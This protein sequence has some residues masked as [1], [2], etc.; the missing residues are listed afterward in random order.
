MVKYRFQSIFTDSLIIIKFFILLTFYLLIS[1]NSQ[2]QTAK[3]YSVDKELSSSMVHDVLQDH[4]GQI[5]IATA[6][7]LNKYD[8]AKFTLY[9]KNNNVSGSILSNFVHVMCEDSQGNLFVGFAGGIQQYDFAADKFITIPLISESGDTLSAFVTSIIER[10]NGK[11]IIGTSGFGLFK[12]IRARE[13]GSFLAIQE[14]SLI[15]SLFIENLYEDSFQNLWIDTQ[16]KGV[17]CLADNNEW[18]N[19]FFDETGSQMEIRSFAED[20]N[21]NFYAGCNRNGMFIYD[22]DQKKFNLL[23]AKGYNNKLPINTLYLNQE[24]EILVGTE[25]EGLM[26]F[27]PINRE[28]S[29][30]NF[31]ISTFDFS[32]SKITSI[33]EDRVGNIWLGIYQKGVVMLPASSNNFQYIGYKSIKNNI[34]GSSNI[35]TLSKD[36]NSSLWVG[37]DGDGIYKL[38]TLSNLKTHYKNT[39]N[40]SAMPSTIMAAFEDSENNFWLGS[41]D[42][43]LVRLNR[44]TGH[45]DLM[46]H[47]LEETPDW[48]K[49]VF[50]IVEDGN[51]NLWIGTL[52]SGLYCYNLKTEQTKHF[53][54]E[55][56]ESFHSKSDEII[57]RFINSLLISSDDRLYIGTV[58]GLG[59]LDLKANSFTSAFGVNRLLPDYAINTIF[60]DQTGLIW[61]GTSQGLFNLDPISEQINSFSIQDG[62]P[63]NV[64]SSIAEDTVGNIWIS[65]N[66]GISKM[67]PKTA[68]FI[69][70]FSYDGLQGNEFTL[71]SGFSDKGRRFYFGGIHGIT[72]FNPLEIKDEGRKLD[73]FF[74][75]FYIH[76]RAVNVGMKSGPF[77]IID[78]PLI[79]ADQINL[80][81]RDNSFTIEFSSMD[82]SNPERISYMY[83]VGN[84]K[85]WISLRQGTNTV[86]FNDLSPGQYSFTVRAKD[87]NTISNEKEINIFIHQPWYFTNTAKI[88][89][90]LL[91]VLIIVLVSR[92][93]RQR[94]R[95]RQKIHE[96]IQAKKIND[97][98]LQFFINVAHEI[99]TPLSLIISPLKKLIQKDRDHERHKSYTIMNRNSVR[100]LHLVNQLMDIQKIDKGQLALKFEQTEI[101]G[102]VKELCDIFEEQL[103]LKNVNINFQFKTEEITAWID[104]GNFDKVIINVLSNAI[105]FTPVDGKIDIS[106]S[107]VEINLPDIGLNSFAQIV[108]SD[109]GIG[110]P[111]NELEKVFDCFYQVND[112]KHNSFDGTGIGLHLSRSIVELH[113]GT[114]T[115][116][117]NIDKEGCRF[118]I[119]IPLGNRHLNENEMLIDHDKHHAHETELTYPDLIEIED[120][121]KVK[122]GSKRKILVVDDDKEIAE[123]I[124]QELSIEY[125]VVQFLNGKEALSFVLKTPPDLVISDVVM[126]EM[127]G[128][129]LCRKIKQNVNINHVPVILLTAKSKEEDNLKGLGIGAEAYIVKPF[130]INILRKTVQNILKNRQM[131]R[132][133]FSGSQRQDDKIKKIALKS[134]DEKL[135]L[136]IIDVVNANISNPELNVEMLAHE[137]GISRVHLHRKLKELTNQST[138]D[139]VRNI[140]LHQ[141]ANLL[142]DKHMN[143]SEVAFAVGFT[144]IAHFSN[145]FKEFYGQPPS[146]YMETHQNQF[147]E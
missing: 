12:L 51:K 45:C 108:I 123:Y 126:P 136:R 131:L 46:N 54:G 41:Y 96:H 2:S 128:I 72:H 47:I 66:Y 55:K 116:K 103:K 14:P 21:G 92:E 83:K 38:D 133:S 3:F 89:Y 111:Q 37:T 40:A 58:I 44:K 109:S 113:H 104:P 35:T 60:E 91:F 23:P 24:G 17:Y 67:D 95:T 15:P 105:K 76:D 42:K 86:T 97:A 33:I 61:I 132:N 49:P 71:R 114:I 90:I 27:N 101:V 59:C 93:V 143:I 56:S 119:R 78:S 130:S 112:G 10:R 139:F 26:L 7:G 135:L 124:R 77:D 9:K 120:E 102:Y 50:S 73:V 107:E 138:R 13:G 81:H 4:Y 70:Y 144:N 100:I 32:K 134:P 62:L 30:G 43:G 68:T 145:A 88:A 31:N 142:S 16:N 5:W 48:F 64:I 25:G 19:F 74:T 52:G 85:D 122:S 11:L 115:A 117:N 20:Q 87:Y 53:S 69:N 137:I 118:T 94:K 75:G 129:T 6:D 29:S 80:S 57:N 63:S 106:I 22:R 39:G 36:R 18:K 34:I 127:D 8:A 28:F 147:N 121:I 140:R 125:Q 84:D 1:K 98:K 146:S 65:T 141:A 82:Y 79:E 110:I 99:R